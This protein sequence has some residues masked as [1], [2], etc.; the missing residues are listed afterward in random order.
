MLENISEAAIGT[1]L[2]PCN[3]RPCIRSI[4]WLGEELQIALTATRK[5]FLNRNAIGNR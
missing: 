5:I 4:G 3:A 1:T 2:N